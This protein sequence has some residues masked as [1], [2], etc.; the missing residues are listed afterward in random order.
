MKEKKKVSL[1][2]LIFGAMV[3]GIVVGIIASGNPKWVTIISTYIKPFGTIFVNLL[4]AV[5]VPVVLVSILASTPLAKF[6]G[7]KYSQSVVV[8]Y[9][10]LVA[11]AVI[12]L[13]CV[14]ALA[15]NS[16]NPFIYFRF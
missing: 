3:L 8:R 13:L 11:C 5:V 15:S 2:L 9:G 6:I 16:Y 14:A 1:P 10:K 12:L 7:D 4:K